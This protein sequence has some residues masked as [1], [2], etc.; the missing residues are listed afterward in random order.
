[1]S[2]IYNIEKKA[3][4]LNTKNSSYQFRVAEFGFLEHLYYGRR[5]EEAVD[6]IPVRLRH[7][8]EAN[9]HTRAGISG[10]RR[11]GF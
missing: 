11:L 9:P 6:Y 8:F 2:I 5:V 3:F 10:L 4:L 7:G 1:M